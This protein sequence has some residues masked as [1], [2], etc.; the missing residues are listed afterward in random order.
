MI[1]ATEINPAS[2][3]DLKALTPKAQTPK[4]ALLGASASVAAL[5][6]HT[7]GL[8][9]T[10]PQPKRVFCASVSCHAGTATRNALFAGRLSS[11]TFLPSSV[12]KK[13][14]RAANGT[15]ILP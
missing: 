3:A 9:H 15:R 10:D 4:C 12:C 2:D 11:I 13:Q 6:Y 7:T 1:S 5:A 8:C 14:Q